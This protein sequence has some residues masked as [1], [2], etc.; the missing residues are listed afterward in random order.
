MKIRFKLLM[1]IL[2]VL[3]FIVP[4][5]VLNVEWFLQKQ[6]TTA[7]IA[8]PE[9]AI[10]GLLCLLSWLSVDYLESFA[11]IFL[12]LVGLFFSLLTI[13]PGVPFIIAGIVFGIF[14]IQHESKETPPPTRHFTKFEQPKKNLAQTQAQLKQQMDQAVKR[15][16]IR[17]TLRL[18][19][20][21]EDEVMLRLAGLDLTDKIPQV[22][23]SNTYVRQE[24]VLELLKREQEAG[25]R[26]DFSGA[27]LR[28]LDFSR[29]LLKARHLEGVLEGA[30]FSSANLLGA[31]F[32]GTNLQGA[33]FSKSLAIRTHFYDANLID[34]NFEMANL[35]G[36]GFSGARLRGARLHQAYLLQTFF[37]GAYLNGAT[38]DSLHWVKDYNR[39]HSF[40]VPFLMRWHKI[41]EEKDDQG[42]SIYILRGDDPPV[43]ARKP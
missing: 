39:M 18:K 42:N 9:L 8:Q 37:M 33:N 40:S 27:D 12:E 25:Y 35:Q 3:C 38:V 4:F 13:I 10:M 41:V 6:R 11:R 15:D 7:E 23:A 26:S 29:R 1:S 22:S 20:R 34:A 16:F 32:R 2:F 31:K 43:E 30:D 24:I 5:L 36:A 21:P 14:L 17:K 19:S 28:D